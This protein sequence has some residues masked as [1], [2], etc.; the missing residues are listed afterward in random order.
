MRYHRESEIDYL[1]V[2]MFSALIFICFMATIARPFLLIVT[3]PMMVIWG[4]M[5]SISIRDIIEEDRRHEKKS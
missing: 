4:Y 5:A 1:W 3:L 2:M